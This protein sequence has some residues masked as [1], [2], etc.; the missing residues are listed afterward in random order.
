MAKEQDYIVGGH[1]IGS[2]EYPFIIH[3]NKCTASLITPSYF[4][5]AAHCILPFKHKRLENRMKKCVE[6]TENGKFV[7]SRR[8]E[9]KIQCRKLL[10]GHWEVVTEP[11]TI[12][13]IGVDNFYDEESKKKGT[14]SPVS[15]NIL[16]RDTYR[17]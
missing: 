13:W 7:Y 1:R 15:R 10:E 2:Q 17:R 14:S 16:H 4:I 9:A 3:W 5:S 11:K 8:L 12:A 6:K